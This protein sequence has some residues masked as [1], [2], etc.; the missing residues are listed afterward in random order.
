MKVLDFIGN[1][2]IAGDAVSIKLDHVVGVIQKIDDGAIARGITLDG[3][4]SGEVL[5]PH[6]VIQIQATQAM[7][8]QAPPNSPVGRVQ[9]VIKIAKP[10]EKK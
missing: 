10:E 5:P 4:P 1:E 6:I 2:L 8:I 9:A 7:L 3:K